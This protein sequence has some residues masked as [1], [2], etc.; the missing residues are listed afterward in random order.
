M[1]AKEVSFDIDILKECQKE[2]SYPITDKKAYMQTLILERLD[3]C[4]KQQLK[5]FD[6]WLDTVNAYVE[7]DDC[8]LFDLARVVTRLSRYSK[9]LCNAELTLLK[10]LMGD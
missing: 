3:D 7:S 1:Y 2:F 4:N 10:S 8:D 5:E 6:S 9:Q